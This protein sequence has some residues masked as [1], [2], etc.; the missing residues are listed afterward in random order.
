MK[1]LAQ[2]RR[3][4]EENNFEL[5]PESDFWDLVE[6][7]GW[8]QSCR[9]GDALKYHLIHQ[10]ANGRSLTDPSVREDLLRFSNTYRLYVNHISKILDE[11]IEV[12]IQTKNLWIGD[13]SFSDLCAHY[14]GLGRE[15]YRQITAPFE[16][17]LEKRDSI[18]VLAHSAR[19]AF[20]DVIQ[21]IENSDYEESFSYVVPHVFSAEH[22]EEEKNALGD[23]LDDDLSYF[24]WEHY[25]KRL[26]REFTDEGEEMP[27][28]AAAAAIRVLP[29]KQ[30]VTP[31]EWDQDVAPMYEDMRRIATLLYEGVLLYKEGKS[32]EPKWK[33]AVK[34]TIPFRRDKGNGGWSPVICRYMDSHYLIPNL[35]TDMKNFL[36]P[37]DF[38]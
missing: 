34:A 20:D 26:E 21:R 31:A 35:T 33:E 13:D 18:D 30:H 9:K 7:V 38:E 37:E 28:T 11:I 36:F 22:L 14:V 5:L 3:E 19:A 2:A 29:D 16:Q 25:A 8:P 10:V 24:T 15:V 17:Q 27:L 32:P 4:A 1:S 6:S 12:A 23:D